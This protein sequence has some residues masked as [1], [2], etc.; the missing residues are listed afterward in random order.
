MAVI[1]GT[2]VASQGLGCQNSTTEGCT[3]PYWLPGTGA[4]MGA[5]N[6]FPAGGFTVSMD[7]YLSPSTAAPVGSIFDNDVAVNNNQGTYGS[8]DIVDACLVSPGTFALA[9]SNGS[10]GNCS[11]T[12]DV[13]TDGWYRYVWQFSDQG[14]DGYVTCSVYSDSGGKHPTL[15]RVFTTGPQPISGTAMPISDWGGPGYWWAPT[16]QFAGLPVANFAIRTGQH[17][18]GYTP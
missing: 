5:E 11:G 7:A 1:T 2:D 3:G 9:F 8:D 14:G 16:L 12:A 18:T 13:T 15:T 6:V 10:P 4:A 17:A